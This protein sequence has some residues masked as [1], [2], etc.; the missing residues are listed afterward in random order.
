M[1]SISHSFGRLLPRSASRSHPSWT[2]FNRLFHPHALLSSPP[3][4]S[5]SSSFPPFSPSNKLNV[6]CLLYPGGDV[7]ASNPSILGCV[8][9]GLG[10]PHWLSQSPYASS[11]SLHVTSSLA[12]VDALLPSAHVAISQPF[13]PLYLTRARLARAP[14]LLYSLTAGVGSDHIDLQ[15]AVQRRL[16]VAEVSGSNVVSVAEQ[17]V[18]TVLLLVKG[19]ME[20]HR[21]VG[22]G[23]WDVAKVVDRAWDLQGKAVGTVGCGRIG[24][25]VLQRLKAFDVA[26]HYTDKFRQPREVEEQLGVTWHPT[27]EALA[28]AVDVLTV[29]CPLHSE[30]EGLIDR[31][32]LSV[33]R[34]NSF[35]VNTARAKI[36]DRDAVVDALKAGQLAG[37]GGRHCAYPSRPCTRPSASQHCAAA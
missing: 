9:N 34:P 3:T 21:Q 32:M 10:L 27:V 24:M 7:G 1:L 36:V 26:L 35:L 19:W 37:Y 28:K 18:L 17:V 16:T 33:M 22:A 30:T 8:E 13:F 4:A 25:R 29:N 20:G 6:V 2:S 5:Q 11:V 12:D 14:H 31:H 15:A 23:E